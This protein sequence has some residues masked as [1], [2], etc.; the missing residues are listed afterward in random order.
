MWRLAWIAHAIRY[1][2]Y[3]PP[4]FHRMREVM[5]TFPDDRSIALLRERNVDYVI[6]RMGLY[7]D[8]EQASRVLEQAGQREELSLE[9]MWTNEADGTEALFR[10]GP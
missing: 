9:G 3:A 5:Q 10:L 4:S 2:G 8:Y 1:S 6:I 7:D